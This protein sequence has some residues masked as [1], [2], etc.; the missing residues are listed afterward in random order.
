M[1]DSMSLHVLKESH[2]KGSVKLCLL[3]A[4]RRLWG[5]DPCAYCQNCPELRIFGKELLGLTV[6]P[7]KAQNQF[8][9]ASE[10]SHI[11]QDK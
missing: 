10:G 8:K 6:Y 2:F 7:I 4:F 3:E 5:K 9:Q 1:I 11:P